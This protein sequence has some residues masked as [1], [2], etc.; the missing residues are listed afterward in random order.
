MPLPRFWGS[1]N[2]LKL[3]SGLKNLKSLASAVAEI[4]KGDPNILGSSPSPGPH[5]FFVLVGFDDGTWLTPTK[6]KKHQVYS[7]VVMLLIV[8]FGYSLVIN[9]VIITSLTYSLVSFFA[10]LAAILEFT[11]NRYFLNH[12]NDFS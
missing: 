2:P 8:S 5:P 11:F 4:L 3:F 10:I 9:I 6:Y 7:P 1:R 12:E